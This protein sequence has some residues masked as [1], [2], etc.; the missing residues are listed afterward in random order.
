[1]KRTGED[2][3]D[4]TADL[5]G[6][7]FVIGTGKERNA[8]TRARSEQRDTPGTRRRRLSSRRQ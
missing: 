8:I 4:L 5:T 2:R 3:I 7:D 6:T 1:M